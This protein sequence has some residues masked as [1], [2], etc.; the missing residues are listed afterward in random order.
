[1]LERLS[2]MDLLELKKII[3][4]SDEINMLEKY[5][6]KMSAYSFMFECN[7]SRMEKYA[8][9]YLGR[10]YTYTELRGKTDICAKAFAEKGIIPG[11][12]VAI[13]SLSTPE[14][15]IAFYAF[16]KIGARVHLINGTHDKQSIKEDLKECNAKMLVINDV[17]CDDE[18]R[19]V[20]DELSIKD[21][22]MT[23]LDDTFPIGFFLDDVKFK[24][25]KLIKSFS[26]GMKNNDK[27][28]SWRKLE[29]IGRSSNKVVEPYYEE[30]AGVVVA[31]TSGSTGKAKKP[32]M[33]NEALNAMAFEMGMSCDAFAPNDSILTTLPIWIFYSL[34]NSIHVPLCLGV[35]VDLDPLF[36][37]TKIHNRLKQYKFNHWNTVPSYVEDL[38]ADKKVK[39]MD[40]SFLKSITTG[41][42][43]RT[44][45]LKM[46]SE[47]KLNN[48]NSFIEVGQGY[49]ASECG[50]CFGYSYEENMA[51]E[52]VGKPLIGNKYKIIEID[53][54]KELGPNEV[55]EIYLYSATMMLEY[56][57]D[58]EATKKSLIT[59]KNGIKW[60]K[61]EDMGHF[62]DKGQLFIDGRIRRIEL[63]RDENGSPA[64]VFPDRI[65][66][67]ISKH[68]DIEQCEV[69]MVPDKKK[70]TVPVAFIVPK[71]ENQ[72]LTSNMIKTINSLCVS[73]NLES[74]S[75]PV[76]YRLIKSIPKT[77]SLKTDYKKLAEEYE[78]AH[79]KK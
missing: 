17:F 41:G 23:S 42:D 48:N 15:I 49:G 3:K 36:N 21:I 71:N 61:T 24:L 20:T 26:N 47:Q 58:P 60:Y 75:I 52:T 32:L 1:M 12:D 4:D 14:A 56:F 31:S 57:N 45:K 78:V 68:P 27:C 10:K 44:P 7:K 51:P 55:G 53:T 67:V 69:I 39:N 37:S 43:Y 74:Y 30:N 16:V 66:Q 28:I 63:T 18:M 13:V 50:G 54:G 5:I 11:D 72:E 76:E 35:T 9:N 46:E 29:K 19:K 33:S 34:F 59:D 40:L 8:L 62:D 64:K 38:V 70:T 25:I 77:A 6:P 65:K 22:V 79:V 73:E 2:K